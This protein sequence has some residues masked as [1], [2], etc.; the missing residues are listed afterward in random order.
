MD[1]SKN[2]LEFFNKH[3]EEILHMVE[4]LKNNGYITLY[5]TQLLAST[6]VSI[7][8]YNVISEYINSNNIDINLYISSIIVVRED[9]FRD[10]GLFNESIIYDTK[11]IDID[12]SGNL[13]YLELL[14]YIEKETSNVK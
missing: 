11:I 7:R 6:A 12:E 5:D 8:L 3:K 9:K 14:K 4:L 10:L 13:L 2:E 1:F